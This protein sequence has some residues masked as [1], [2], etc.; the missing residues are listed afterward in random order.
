MIQHSLAQPM[1][2]QHIAAM[3]IDRLSETVADAVRAAPCSLRALAR[4]ADVPDST[5]V[6]I[7]SGERAATPAVAAAIATALF[8]W[9]RTCGKLG[10]RIR[11]ALPRIQS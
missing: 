11:Q 4:A 9:S 3:L 6:R 10:T 2:R 1:R 8:E 5:L 7:V